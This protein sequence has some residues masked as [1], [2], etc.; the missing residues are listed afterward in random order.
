MAQGVGNEPEHGL[1]DSAP[2][3]ESESIVVIDFGSQYSLL[4]TRRIRECNV[5]SELVSY[6]TPW[7]KVKELNPKGFILSGGPSS[8]YEENA[9]VAPAY[10]YESHLP[11]LGICYGMH[12]I[13]N[14]LGGKVTPGKKREFGH[15]VLHIGDTRSPLLA[16]LDTSIPVWMSHGDKVEEMPPGFSSLAY[17]ENTPCA[18][19]GN[20]ENIY[21]LQFHPEVAHTPQGMTILK[22]FAYNVCGCEG[23]WTIKNF[24]NDSIDSI[25]KTVG[26]GKVINALSGGVDSSVVATLIHRAVGDQLTCIFVNNGLLRLDEADN[27]QK[28]FRKNLGMNILYIDAEDRF[29]NRLKGV[30]DPETK[31]KIIGEEF[32]EVFEEEANKIGTVDFL[33]QG[34]LYPDVIES[35]ASGSSASAV[36]KSHH[37]V[38]GLPDRMRLNLVEPLRYLFKDEVRKV[39]LELGM[40]ED[41]I[42]RQP[43][44][45]PGLAVRVI[46]D[47]T[48][49]KLDILRA[50]DA[51]VMDEIREANLYRSVWQSFAVLTDVKSV[52]VMG[53]YRTYG[54]LIAIRAVTSEDAMTA[55]WAR[56]PYDLLSRMSNRIVNEVSG[57]NRVVYDIT[58]KPPS[59]IEWE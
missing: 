9:P 19:M 12:V 52:G 54:Y 45:G 3:T 14:Q 2:V 55:D 41:M 20:D 56:L 8:V 10:I 18:V 58:S 34:T 46:G 48:R 26:E 5:Y 59:T 49:E 24:I 43:F 25:R 22:N 50:A 37:N 53:D 42:W 44:P 23:N 36:I 27:I 28:M 57:V 4:I 33:A 1:Q 30:T 16:G 15:A 39:G 40:P 51:I 31:R 17:T 47:I 38:G 7:E 6:D 21:G 35:S 11:V 29:L 32:I 13:S